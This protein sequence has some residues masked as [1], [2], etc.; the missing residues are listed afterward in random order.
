MPRST[1][2]I[3]ERIARQ[4]AKRTAADRELKRLK[5]TEKEQAEQTRRHV[6]IV[7]GIPLIEHA[8]RNPASE[9]RRVMIR[10]LENH[11]TIRPN[12][13]PVAELLA[14]LKAPA[15]LPSPAADAKTPPGDDP[16]QDEAESFS[17]AAA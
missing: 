10:V 16:L 3:E 14:R 2:T 8:F 15:P 5:A 12:D 6:G 1:L 13:P 11:M 4:E 9:V 17:G 7:V